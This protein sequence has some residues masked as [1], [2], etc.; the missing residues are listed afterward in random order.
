VALD[1]FRQSPDGP[2]FQVLSRGPAWLVWRIGATTI[3]GRFETWQEM[4]DYTE[5]RLAIEGGGI[6][7]VAGHPMY[8]PGDDRSE[9]PPRQ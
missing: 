9:A 5:E 7:V 2:Q 6:V 8:A 4:K 1:R 3:E